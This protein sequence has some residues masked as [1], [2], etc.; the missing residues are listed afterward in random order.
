[1]AML[2][3]QAM[4]TL[5]IMVCFVENVENLSDMM[6]DCSLKDMIEVENTIDSYIKF[7]D[8]AYGYATNAYRKK[9][10][11]YLDLENR[12]FIYLKGNLISTKK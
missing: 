10:S 9:L 2:I 5:D 8:G 11:V 7:K 6:N 1:M 12:G 3:N 4:H